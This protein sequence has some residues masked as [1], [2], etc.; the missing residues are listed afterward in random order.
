[1]VGV[2]ESTVKRW[3]DAGHIR[4]EKTVGGHRR[5]A[6]GELLGFLRR[7]G[8]PAPTVETLGLLADGPAAA[9]GD[10]PLSGEALCRLLLA[11][12]VGVAR[13]LLLE[14]YSAGRALDE[15]GD[16]VVAPAM[17]QVGELE[18]RGVIG[19]HHEHL[20]TQRLWAILMELHALL[21]EPGERA[22]LALGGAPE[23][24]P[25][26]LPGLTVELTLLDLGWRAL[27]LGPETPMPVLAQAV[28]EHRPR[29]VWLSITARRPAP[30]LVDAYPLVAEAARARHAGIIVG[31]QGVTPE[32]Q[33]HLAAAAFGTRLAHLREFARTL[34]SSR[35]PRA[36]AGKE[37]R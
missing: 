16:A 34:W 22:P 11:G 7:R 21:P 32:L 14:A 35:R 37:R 25:Y 5:I 1:M 2:S 19:I 24:D 12:D 17:T 31:G 4:A 28:R 10:L 33:H 20:A 23:G 6:L 3:V 15:L 13:R 26:L 36:R 8:R 18:A 30:S 9:P 27:N 29:L